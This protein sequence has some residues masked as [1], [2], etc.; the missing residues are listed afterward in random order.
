MNLASLF[1]GDNM[2][3]A[4]LALASFVVVFLFWIAL[5]DDNSAERRVRM[6]ERR[7]S[8]LRSQ[9]ADS[10]GGRANEAA[11]MAKGVVEKLNLLPSD[12]AKGAAAEL[13]QAGY[14]TKDAIFI[15]TFSRLAMPLIGWALG[16]FLFYVLRV[17]DTEANNLLMGALM[18]GIVFGLLPSLFLR[19]AKERR[20]KSMSRSLPDAL[21]LFVICAEAGLSLD[22]TFERVSTEL[23]E[24]HPDLA[25]EFGLTSVEL[26]FM[27]DRSK[28]LQAL[29]ERCQ[30][31]GVRSLVSTLVQTER[32]GTPLAVS[33]RVLSAEMRNERMMKAEEKAAR[34]PAIMTVPMILFILPP[35]FIVLIGPAI[36]RSQDAFK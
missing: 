33:M 13:A 34:L 14:R 12:S 27:P 11:A 15:Y 5:L 3:P 36:L 32:Y 24:A 23:S 17:W 26:G 8:D 21:D 2:L 16:F 7:R 35:L 30:L 29:A 28:A 19:K 25:D 6:L 9:L 18:V 22:A 20:M 31:Q 10:K 1:S 4:L